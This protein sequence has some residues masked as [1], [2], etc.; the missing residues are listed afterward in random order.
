MLKSI[1]RRNNAV[2]DNVVCKGIGCFVSKK[3][4]LYVEN[5]SID[6]RAE[7]FDTPTTAEGFTIRMGC[8]LYKEMKKRDKR[9]IGNCTA[10]L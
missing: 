3:C 10:I 5:K 1:R 9:N 2:L 8:A 6:D 4:L 7:L